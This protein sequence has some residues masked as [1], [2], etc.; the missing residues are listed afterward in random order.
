MSSLETQKVRIAFAIRGTLRRFVGTQVSF[1]SASLIQIIN[2]N[3]AMEVDQ[4]LTKVLFTEPVHSPNFKFLVRNMV[5]SLNEEELL[6]LVS[7][8]SP[9]HDCLGLD[10]RQ[11][12]RSANF[13]PSS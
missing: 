3:F 7:L 12:L 11:R 8:C 6:K 9:I 4:D 2:F 1:P 5:N 13:C 10:D